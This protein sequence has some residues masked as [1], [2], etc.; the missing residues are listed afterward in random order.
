M[1][2]DKIVK[3]GKLIKDIENMEKKDNGKWS[4]RGVEKK[5]LSK[6]GYG[7]E[8]QARCKVIPNEMIIRRV[9]LVPQR[10]VQPQ[11]VRLQEYRKS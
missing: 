6:N 1:E 10:L 4:K 3:D 5:Y 7:L 2:V 8:V 11:S 9:R